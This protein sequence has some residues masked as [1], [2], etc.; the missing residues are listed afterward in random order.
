MVLDSNLYYGRRA[1]ITFSHFNCVLIM[2]KTV[3]IDYVKRYVAVL[4]YAIAKGVAIQIIFK[5]KTKKFV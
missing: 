4:S 2:D 5:I 3:T 1:N